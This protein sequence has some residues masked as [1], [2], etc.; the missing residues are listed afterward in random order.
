MYDSFCEYQRRLLDVFDSMSRE[1]G[2]HVIE[3]AAQI[4]DVYD[5]IR[6][7]LAPL[8]MPA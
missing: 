4:D 3:T 1:D 8:L 2:F 7:R 5:R 6:N